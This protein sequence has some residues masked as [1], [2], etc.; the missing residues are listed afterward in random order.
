[1]RLDTADFRSS[2]SDQRKS[3]YEETRQSLLTPTRRAALAALE[4]EF[5]EFLKAARASGMT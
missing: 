1:M 2:Q 5:N 4:R 3:E